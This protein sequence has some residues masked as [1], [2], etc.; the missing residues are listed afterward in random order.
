MTGTLRLTGEPLRICLV[1]R[2]YP[3]LGSHGGIGTY[4]QNLVKGLTGRGHR[5]TVIARALAGRV[6]AG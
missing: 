2:E 6:T 5:V 3:R 1:T 4:T